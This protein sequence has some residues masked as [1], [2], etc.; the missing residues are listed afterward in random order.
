MDEGD[1]EKNDE[2]AS[3]LERDVEIIERAMEKKIKVTKKGK[4]VH[5]NAKC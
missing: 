1:D 4:P 5:L 2:D 3:A